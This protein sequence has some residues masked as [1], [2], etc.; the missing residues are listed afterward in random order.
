MVPVIMRYKRLEAESG[1]SSRE[2]GTLREFQLEDRLQAV[3]ELGDHV[4]FLSEKRQ[5]NVLRS[6]RRRK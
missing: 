3:S 4:W 6:H 1:G 2:R 5:I